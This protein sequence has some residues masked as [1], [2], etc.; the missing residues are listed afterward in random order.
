MD[1]LYY[2][3]PRAGWGSIR[4]VLGDVENQP[5]M[6]VQDPINFQKDAEKLVFAAQ[7]EV[8]QAWGQLSQASRAGAS[9]DVIELHK[10]KLQQLSDALAK[11]QDD[12]AQ[13]KQNGEMKAWS[14]RA[15]DTVMQVHS[16]LQTVVNL[17]QGAITGGGYKGLLLGFGVAAVVAIAGFYVWKR[18]SRR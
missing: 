11:L 18:R 4:R 15:V 6:D 7:G 8:E 13:I 12:S 14:D 5:P 1:P 10:V 2:T 3:V 9:P 16:E 17:N